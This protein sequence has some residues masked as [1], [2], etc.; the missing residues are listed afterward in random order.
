MR[1]I[2][3]SNWT[4]EINLQF[5]YWS[6][7]LFFSIAFKWRR[8]SDMVNHC[9]K[10]PLLK[11]GILVFQVSL[12]TTLIKINNNEKGYI[13]VKET[14]QASHQQWN[15]KKITI[16]FRSGKSWFDLLKKFT[17]SYSLVITIFSNV[18]FSKLS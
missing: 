15:I 7:F 16:F 9:W 18:M 1:W 17:I 4:F 5:F 2:Q 6:I 13:Q 11:E 10:F 12:K 3:V 14:I 8:L